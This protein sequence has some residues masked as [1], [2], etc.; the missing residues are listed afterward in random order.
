MLTVSTA[1]LPKLA[2]PSPISFTPDLI[3]PNNPPSSSSESSF[4]K[5]TSSLFL[6]FNLFN[7]LFTDR[8]FY[9]FKLVNNIFLIKMKFYIKNLKKHL[10][11][12]Q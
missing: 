4:L 3:D 8:S 11:F 7:F 6:M 12:C 5:T 10:S 9:F 1:P 2:A